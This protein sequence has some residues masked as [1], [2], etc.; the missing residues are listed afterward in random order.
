MSQ[1]QDFASDIASSHQKLYKKR[2]VILSFDQFLEKLQAEPIALTRNAPQ[3]ILDT[4]DYFGVREET[5]GQ[6]FKLFDN[7]KNSVKSSKNPIVGNHRVHTQIYRSL[8]NFV[9]QGATNKLILLHGPNGSAKTS[10]VEAIAS[11]MHVYSQSDEGCVY[12]FNW[13]FPVSKFLTPKSSGETGPIGFKTLGDQGKDNYDSYAHLSEDEISSK[14]HSEYHENPIF[15]L[16]MPFREDFLRKT[17]AA[18]TG[19]TPEN[20]KI[21]PQ[22]LLSGLCKKNQLIFDNLLM[23][24]DGDLR[25][26]FRHI[27]IERF[28]YSK[29]YRVGVSTVEPQMSLDAR[30]IQL[31]MD[32]NIANLPSVLNNIRFHEAQGQLIEA[33]RGLLE[34]SD[35]LK[36]PLETY[37]YLLTLVENQALSLPSSTT[38]LDLVFIATSNEKHL[39]AFKTIPDFASFRE[40]FDLITVPYL[41]Q[42]KQEEKIYIEDIKS[43]SETCDICPHTLEYLCVW[44][45][46]TRL[47]QPDPEIY[48]KDVQAI[49][50]KLDPRDKVRLYNNEPL[51]ENFSDLESTRLLKLRRKVL[52]ESD[53]LVIY[54]GRFGASPREVRSLLH[55]AAENSPIL[56]PMV[57]FLELKRLCRDRT[58]F[59][60]LQF[61]ARGKFHDV[62]QFIRDLELEFADVFEDEIINSMDFVD[63][64]KYDELMQRY[65]QHVAA[66]IKKE[67][68]FDQVT[69]SYQQASEKLMENVEKI[70][71]VSSSPADFRQSLIN[72][73]AA[74]KLENKEK[75][76]DLKDVFRD[77]FRQTRDHYSAM[78]KSV[79]KDILKDM[80]TIVNN[81]ESKLS[82]ERIT[83]A[84]TTFANLE[85]KFKYSRAAAGECVKF[86]LS[87]RTT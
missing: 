38:F 29:Q 65:I 47:K 11:A 53:G 67:K 2:N 6:R 57:L 32:K 40:R 73:I 28:Y 39:D 42:S 13:I 54:E 18:K 33:N 84:N 51:S 55:R 36:R 26:V 25:K 10:T 68:L 80:L 64:I 66:F 12:S 56:T 30:E 72:R 4:F 7:A 14:I 45:V 81:E 3:Y 70:L 37:K 43:L 87:K 1:V 22:L 59:E 62:Q 21:P 83:K 17:F 23:A 46:E 77:L 52:T 27:Q 8:K 19:E 76:L 75:E 61:E 74:Y 49:I 69:E 16:P 24:Y 35:L 58:I 82:R 9:R 71:N 50:A 20:V 78:K 79:I 86:L 41:L 15:I 60:F 5:D 85:K 48:D 31:T 34:F 44:A 63:D